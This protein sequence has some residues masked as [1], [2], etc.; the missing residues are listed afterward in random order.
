MSIYSLCGST[1]PFY[2]IF[3]VALESIWDKL[4][5]TNKQTQHAP[6]VT[7]TVEWYIRIC[8]YQCVYVTSPT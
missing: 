4:H 2:G 1:R 6:V 5:I 7:L 8:G 3:I